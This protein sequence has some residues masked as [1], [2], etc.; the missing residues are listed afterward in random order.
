MKNAF[1]NVIGPALNIKFTYSEPISDTGALTTFIENS[2]AAGADAVITNLSS[3][4]DQ[5]AAVCNDLGP[6]SYTHLDVYKRQE[7]VVRQNY[8]NWIWELSA[9][10]GLE[11][12]HLL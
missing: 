8:L 6:V 3:S 10:L 11:Q 12:M 2:Y 9:Y 5:A 1:D 4:I 7:K